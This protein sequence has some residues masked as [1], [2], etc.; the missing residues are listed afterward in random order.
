MTIEEVRDLVATIATVNG[1]SE[2]AHSLEDRLYIQVL[3][4]IAMGTGAA[5][6]TDRVFHDEEA[7]QLAREALKASD[8]RFA[9]W[10]A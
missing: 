1:D 8:I 6:Q 9:R 2:V 3:E 7:A 5:H 4:H 10:C